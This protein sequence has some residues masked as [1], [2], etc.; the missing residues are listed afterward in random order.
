MTVAEHS[1]VGEKLLGF[2]IQSSIVFMLLNFRTGGVNH[3]LA[4][5][6]L[7]LSSTNL[8]RI[9]FNKH[10]AGLTL[11]P[12]GF[13]D[14]LDFPFQTFCVDTRLHRAGGRGDSSMCG[15]VPSSAPA[16]FL[17][18]TQGSILLLSNMTHYSLQHI[19]AR[20]CNSSCSDSTFL[21]FSV[22]MGGRVPPLCRME[23]Y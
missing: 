7:C 18:R 15:D 12:V 8:M 17:M 13:A 5:L 1:L 23:P 9:N 11:S 19:V 4:A 20:T 6:F 3:V 10:I 22:A 16:T 21:F 14:P 2:I